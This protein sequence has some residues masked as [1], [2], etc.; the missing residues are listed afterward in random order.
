MDW[1]GIGF[2]DNIKGENK[3]RKVVYKRFDLLIILIGGNVIRIGFFDMI[4]ENF[5]EFKKPSQISTLQ[6]T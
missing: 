2:W 4:K 5:V 3:F 6:M 1:K